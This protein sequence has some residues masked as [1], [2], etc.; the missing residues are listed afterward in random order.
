[1]VRNPP[2]T[3]LILSANPECSSSIRLAEAVRGIDK[4]LTLAKCRNR[5]N[6]CFRWTSRLK[7][8]QRAILEICPQF[9]HFSGYG[10]EGLS[11]ED[12]T[13]VVNLVNSEEI[14]ELF[15]LF[16]DQI[17]CVLLNGCYSEIQAR[18]ITE[19]VPHVIGISQ[20]VGAAATREFTVG[21]YDALIA[22][23]SIE[24]AFKYGRTNYL[25]TGED[26]K[27]VV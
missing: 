2:K 16:T 10:D 5:Y 8:V 22:G 14:S 21:F 23:Q 27:S 20:A 12:A 11:L 9:I 24:F 13:G 7:D 18:G 25:K 1:M 6:L 17:E 15:K 19:H 3:I 4:C 26:R